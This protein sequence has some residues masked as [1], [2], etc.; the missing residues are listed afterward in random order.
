MIIIF[1]SQ[2]DENENR[3]T[4]DSLDA[5]LVEFDDQERPRPPEERPPVPEQPS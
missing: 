3:V 1:E 4:L 5:L 2:P